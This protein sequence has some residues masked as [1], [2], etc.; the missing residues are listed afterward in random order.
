[1]TAYDLLLVLARREASLVDEGRWAD[2]VALWDQREALQAS[3]P[4][5]PPAEAAPALREA[6][7][8]AGSTEARLQ[9]ELADVAA[10]LRRLA[11]SRRAAIAY[12][13]SSISPAG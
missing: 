9:A 7:E 4:E 2:V 13:Q 1:M 11:E 5:T 12:S 6:L 8:V 3:L 10:E